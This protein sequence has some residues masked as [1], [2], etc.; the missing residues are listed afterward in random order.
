[1]K[2]SDI[3]SQGADRNAN[4]KQRAVAVSEEA[5][6]LAAPLPMD[7][8]QTD[9]TPLPNAVSGDLCRSMLADLLG[10]ALP[11]S[12]Q[13]SGRVQKAGH[14]FGSD[15]GG[16]P[17]QPMAA[18]V[19]GRMDVRAGG[20]SEASAGPA[21]QGNPPAEQSVSNSLALGRDGHQDPNVPEAGLSGRA[22]QAFTTA[23]SSASAP[24]A[25]S[26]QQLKSKSYILNASGRKRLSLRE[27]VQLMHSQQG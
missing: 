4:T 9:A 16:L 2:S 23:Q 12:V 3:Q 13:P 18:V 5:A 10:D 11:M 25:R 21:A 26:Y 8:G 6:P 22:R 17:G 27:R 24:V 19:H 7:R 1:V 14:A 20:P 15:A